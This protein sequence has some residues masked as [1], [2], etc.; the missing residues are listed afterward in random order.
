MLR[1]F[2]AVL[3]SPIGT[4]IGAWSA[5]YLFPDSALGQKVFVSEGVTYGFGERAS[6][7]ALVFFFPNKLSISLALGTYIV[8]VALGAPIAAFLARRGKFPWWVAAGL[9]AILGVAT[10]ATAAYFFHSV[11]LLFG[12]QAYEY[13]AFTGAVAAMWYW[14]AAYVGRPHAG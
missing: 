8:V 5:Q 13:A 10:L 11:L 14:V 4:S 7:T 1:I 2:A 9:G 3:L 6:A 12:R